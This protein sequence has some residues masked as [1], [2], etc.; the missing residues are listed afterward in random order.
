[1]QSPASISRYSRTLT[2]IS[3]AARHTLKP[4]RCRSRRIIVGNEAKDATVKSLE[5]AMDSR[6]YLDVR[7][8]LSSPRGEPRTTGEH[9]PPQLARLT[10]PPGLGSP[11]PGS[12]DSVRP[13]LERPHPARAAARRWAT[14]G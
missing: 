10:R 2:P 8:G 4:S 5:P 12:G 11:R 6:P 3:H 9:F 7:A 14:R 13:S 1:M